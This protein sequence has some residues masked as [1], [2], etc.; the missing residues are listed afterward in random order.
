[1]KK[2]IFNILIISGLFFSI[3]PEIYSIST[4]V[5][6]RIEDLR[7]DPTASCIGASTFYG[8]MGRIKAL[9]SIPPSYPIFMNLTKVI[10][11]T[12]IWAG[13]IVK[14]C[15]EDNLD[16]QGCDY[17]IGDIIMIPDSVDLEL[18]TNYNLFMDIDAIRIYLPLRNKDG[19][20]ATPDDNYWT[21]GQ[22]KSGS[23]SEYCMDSK[24]ICEYS[25]YFDLNGDMFFLSSK[26]NGDLTSS[27]A[28][29]STTRNCDDIELMGICQTSSSNDFNIHDRYDNLYDSNHGNF[30][31][32]FT[33]K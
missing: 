19:F 25:G 11:N 8:R 16:G 24:S 27:C 1:M 2:I 3:F 30:L 29:D 31:F 33:F 10:G 7:D 21:A 6:L 23:N 26:R 5:G 12:Q 28:T 22:Q 9:S 15:T 18:N 13:N 20:H 4:Y 17:T 32:G 14:N